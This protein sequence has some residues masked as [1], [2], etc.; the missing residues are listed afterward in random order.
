VGPVDPDSDP[1]HWFSSLPENP[2]SARPGVNARVCDSDGPGR[3]ADC[4][5]HV[6][7]VCCRLTK[8]IQYRV[9]YRMI[10]QVQL[11]LVGDHRHTRRSLLSES[12]L[13]TAMPYGKIIKII[14]YSNLYSPEWAVGS[15]PFRRIRIHR[16]PFQPNVK[17]IYTLFHKIS[18]YY[19]NI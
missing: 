7:L 1:Q 12:I 19:P 8:N 17:L 10:L 13:S 11:A 3:V 2:L 16:F 4:H 6:P 15:A 5:L 9:Y 18:I 14:G